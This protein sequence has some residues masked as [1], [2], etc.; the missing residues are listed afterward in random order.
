MRTSR[1]ASWGVLVLLGAAAGCS[2]G[3]NDVGASA[4]PQSQPERGY[5]GLFDGTRASF[6]R[7]HMSGPGS[8]RLAGCEL[9]S[10]GGL[11]LLW[12]GSAFSS[13]SLRVDWKV[14]GDDNSGVF[15]GFP[16]PGD[17][18]FVAV[19]QGHEVQI[20]ATDDAGW[21]TGALYGVDAPDADA[22]DRALRPPGEWNT[23]QITVDGDRVSVDL[24]GV[25]VN[26]YVD[27]DPVRM[28]PPSHVGLQNH[29][30]EDEVSFRSVR[31]REL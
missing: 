24:N 8:F 23:F 7:W 9:R 26:D 31:I 20:D 15:I 1:R 2:D 22:R 27:A 16:D 28:S 17:D 10:Q 13:Y 14:A 6:E 4:C 5:Q 12:H 11:G 30:D 21:T 19:N 3:G 18:P 25:R 29:S